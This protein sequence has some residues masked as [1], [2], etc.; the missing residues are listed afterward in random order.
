[1]TDEKFEIRV[2]VD[3]IGHF[4]YTVAICNNHRTS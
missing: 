2:W 4:K 1:M 3:K